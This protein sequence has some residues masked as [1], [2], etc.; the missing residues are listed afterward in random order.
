MSFLTDQFLKNKL[1]YE[2]PEARR[3]VW[4]DIF[5]AS[6]GNTEVAN[7]I[8]QDKVSGGNQFTHGD[9]GQTFSFDDGSYQPPEPTVPESP[10]WFDNFQSH[11]GTPDAMISAGAALLSGKGLGGGLNAFQGSLEHTEQK[12]A[13]ASQQAF[14]N[15]LTSKRFGLQQDQ[16]GYN[17]ERDVVKD[18]QWERGF[19]LKEA[20]SIMKQ[21]AMPYDLALKK[22]QALL[23]MRKAN[24]PNYGKSTSYGQYQNVLDKEGKRVAQ[25]RLGTDGSAINL[26]GSPFNFDPEQHVLSKD[27]VKRDRPTEMFYKTEQGKD[28]VTFDYDPNRQ[29]HFAYIDGKEISKPDFLKQHSTAYKATNKEIGMDKEPLKDLYKTEDE[30]IEVERGFRML[31]RFETLVKETPDGIPRVFERAMG[32]LKTLIGQGHTLSEIQKDVKEGGNL[33]QSIVG[34][35]R[36]DVVGGGV[37]TEQDAL[38]VLM[39]M[40][41]DPNTM[42]WNTEIALRMVREL[43]EQR[44]IDLRRRF[45]NY[46]HRRTKRNLSPYEGTFYKPAAESTQQPF[47]PPEGAVIHDFS[48]G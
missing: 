4:N 5:T 44:S 20:D 40:G 21:Q 36:E 16:L 8:V 30:L 18:D 27:F 35:I 17:Q 11:E 31:D 46:N 42:T 26:D 37:M 47:T 1:G 39:A 23:A 43:K 45:D 41:G 12:A 13:Q 19:V 14:D 29:E 10:S 38:R 25:V 28:L 32:S 7:Q 33:A 3:S 48:G 2:T 15:D 9:L 34:L 24:D 22:A 6:N